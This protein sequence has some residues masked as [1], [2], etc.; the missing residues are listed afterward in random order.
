MQLGCTAKSPRWAIAFKF[1]AEQVTTRLLSVDFQVGRT[2]TV[3]PVANL[4]P[5]LLAG[6]VVKR[7]SLH[8][9]DIIASLDI[10]IG[11]TVF[12]EKGGEIIP[13]ITGV[14]LS[15]REP[16]IHPLTFINRCPECHTPLLKNEGEA[17]WFCPN[18]DGCP[19]QIKGKLEHFISRRAM[20][21]ESLGEGKIELLYDK[22]LVRDPS[23]LYLL[24]REQLLGLEK[25][26][27]AT[28]GK[29]ERRIS[30]REKS[31]VKILNGINSSKAAGFERVLFALGIRYVGE[32][33]AKKLAHHFVSM[34]A[35][36]K[37]DFE[38]LISVEEIG[39]RIASSLISWFSEEA[40]K[41]MIHKL[42]ENGIK[43]EI[44]QDLLLRKSN[45]LDGSVFVVSGIFTRFSRDEIKK[46]I[47]D[48]GGKNSSSISSK[49]SYLLAGDQVG[50]E[51]RKKAE[52]IGI[53][54]ISESDFIEM[55]S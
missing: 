19:P 34:E 39:E 29:K 45:K 27:E 52:M 21:I 6:T 32:T 33:V 37:A 48:H 13:K 28:E 17:A 38:E 44:E 31:V 35:L 54:I 12:V 11:D 1:K 10:R 41:E 46:A 2:G 20:N 3:T 7:A 49:T 22:G 53:P 40:H 24:T 8:N 43:M 18:A 25:V 15:K 42:K 36:M 16:G 30:F 14:E 5:V 50:V 23:D 26:H 51:K 55:I 4:H 9:A 47:E